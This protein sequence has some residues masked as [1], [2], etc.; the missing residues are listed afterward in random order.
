MSL[1]NTEPI[2]VGLFPKFDWPRVH[3]PKIDFAPDGS[4]ENDIEAEEARAYEE[5]ESAFECYKG[6]VAGII[7]EPMQGEGG[8][9]HF[10]TEF[11]TR[12]R[13]YADREEALLI[14][15]EV[16]TGFFGS[17]KAWFW[18][19]HGVRP[20]VVSFGKKTQV[21]GLYAGPRVDEVPDNVF[22]RSSRI[23]STWG[24]NLVD[25]VRCRKFLEIIHAE[26][27]AENVAARGEQLISGLRTLAGEHGQFSN[28]RGRGSLVAFTLSSPEERDAMMGKMLEKKML[29]LGTGEQG[30]RFRLPLVI[31]EDEIGTALDRIAQ[32]LPTRA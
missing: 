10:R 5:I 3:N 4:I 18:E 12:L 2:K 8:D 13:E 6:R 7:I 26:G 9:N 19:H 14:Y 16:Q 27:L 23:N 29:V 24:G 11:L 21:C 32:C 22:V 15:D 17:G 31:T 20:D 28:V 30:I 1:T 25:M